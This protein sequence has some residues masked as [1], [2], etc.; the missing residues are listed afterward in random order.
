MAEVTF[1]S[2]DIGADPSIST[3]Q[4]SNHPFMNRKFLRFFASV[5]ILAFVLMSGLSLNAQPAPPANLLRQAYATLSV[6]DHDYKGHRIEAM[7]QIEAAAKLMRMDLRGDGRGHEKQ[8]VSDEQLRIA[9]GLL[10][11]ASAGL[12]GKPLKHVERAINQINVALKIR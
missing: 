8:V 2:A 4:P 11:Q 12:T 10:Q 7:K 9:R 3:K 1:G 6:A 5:A